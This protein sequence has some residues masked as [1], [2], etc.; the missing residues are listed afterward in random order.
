V[1]DEPLVDTHVHFWDHSV[2][3][4]HWPMFDPGWS[5]RKLRG[6]DQLDAPHYL[7]PLLRVEMAGVDVAALVHVEAAGSALPDPVLETRWLEDVADEHGWPDAIVGSCFFW[8]DDAPDVLARHATH[9]RLRAVRDGSAAKRLDVD[10]ASAALDAAAALGL[11][12]EV[13]RHHEELAPVREIADR[14]PAVVVALSHACLPS[15]RTP[16]SLSAWRKAVAGLGRRPNVVCK[17]SA[18]AGASDPSWTPASVRP[19]IEACIEAFGPGRCMFGS[20]WPIDRLFGTY[21]AVIDAYRSATADLS[22]DERAD[23]FHRTACRVYRL[24]PVPSR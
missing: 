13:R 21:P 4:L 16:D 23:V 2:E 24:P 14:W 20:N 19:W 11:A 8:Q 15:D 5:H 12:I 1:A 10:A 22:T 18:V 6:V 17:I 3:G 7:P 9:P